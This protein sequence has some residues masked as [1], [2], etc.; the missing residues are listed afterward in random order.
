MA[1]LRRHRKTRAG[2]PIAILSAAVMSTITQA[3]TPASNARPATSSLDPPRAFEI[4]QPADVAALRERLAD[5]N[6]DISLAGDVLTIM[7]RDAR[8]SVVVSGSLQ[9]PMSRI[10]GSDIWYV[11]LKRNGWDRAFFSYLFAARLPSSLESEPMREYR[12]SRAPVLTRA[13]SLTGRIVVRQ[14]S[15]KH[16]NADRSVSIYLPPDARA[17]LPV[18]FMADGAFMDRFARVLEPLILAGRIEPIAIVGTH[19]SV[20]PATRPGLDRR[21]Q[22]YVPVV[23]PPIFAQHLQFLIEEVVP[24]VTREFQLSTRPEDRALFGF[25]SGAAFAVAAVARHPGTFSHALAFSLNLPR[26]E[27]A[28]Q[29][30]PTY[31]FAAGELEPYFLKT[32]R[33]VHEQLSNA[34]TRSTFRSY[35]SGHNLMLWQL[36]LSEYLPEI[37]PPR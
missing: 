24:A 18:L 8:D 29:L 1:I 17:P 27:T 6:D 2:M 9:T 23:A 21:A 30:A 13:R 20:E 33:G 25:S 12:G 31:Y 7:H 16:L 28:K 14:I 19:A 32:T 34:G 37:F 4:V 26:V 36:A 35:L 5:R 22:E 3:Q 10:P 11:H 15:S